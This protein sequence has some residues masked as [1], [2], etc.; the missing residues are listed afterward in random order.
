M[1]YIVNNGF[2]IPTESNDEFGENIYVNLTKTNFRM[3]DTG[4]MINWFY[5]NSS[6]YNYTAP[7]IADSHYKQFVQLVWRNTTS[8]GCAFN[9]SKWVV[10]VCK[11]S[12]KISATV[13]D[14]M[15]NVLPPIDDQPIHDQRTTEKSL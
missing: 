4:S 7:P 12:P 14:Y 15:Y 10:A 11:Y 5:A 3:V 9:V 2:I 1:D 6:T 8:F 13:E